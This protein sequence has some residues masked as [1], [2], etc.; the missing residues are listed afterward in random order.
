MQLSRWPFYDE[1][2]INAV[3]NVLFS[4]KVN[5]WTGQETNI[6]FFVFAQW[7]GTDYAI[8]MANGSLALS[9]A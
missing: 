3:T 8:A 9:S 1:D 4:G 6:F 2:Q 7:C 5:N